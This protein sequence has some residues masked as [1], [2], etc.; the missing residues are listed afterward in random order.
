ME[1]TYG[2]RETIVVTDVPEDFVKELKQTNDKE[3]SK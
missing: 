1:L 3:A 2:K